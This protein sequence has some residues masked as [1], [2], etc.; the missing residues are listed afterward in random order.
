MTVFTTVALLVTPVSITFYFDDHEYWHTIN[1][2]MNIVFFC[3]I[4]L[5]FFTGYYD[6]RTKMIILDPRIVAL[7]VYSIIVMLNKLHQKD[8]YVS[9]VLVSMQKVS[10]EVFPGRFNDHSTDK[11]RRSHSTKRNMV[12]H[13]SEH[14]EI[15]TD[16]QYNLIFP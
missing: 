13:H 15:V 9:K 4:V 7:Y 1:D 11:F 12:L 2:V 10:Q 3:D 8:F 5:W 6:Y 16:P 14:D